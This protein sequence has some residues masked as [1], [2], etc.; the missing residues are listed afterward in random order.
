MAI[1]VCLHQSREAFMLSGSNDMWLFISLCNNWVA[2]CRRSFLISG[3]PRCWYFYQRRF[4]QTASPLHCLSLTYLAS[5]S[6]WTLT[7]VSLST[8]QLSSWRKIYLYCLHSSMQSKSSIAHQRASNWLLLNRHQQDF[9]SNPLFVSAIWWCAKL[10]LPKPQYKFSNELV[11]YSVNFGCL[12]AAF[13]FLTSAN[14]AAVKEKIIQM[15]CTLKP[16]GLLSASM[17]NSC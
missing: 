3:W 9:G 13:V 12:L 14:K 5:C 10:N 17:D 15:T 2:T 8:F 1:Y 7:A 6:P 4:Y 16:T 11:E